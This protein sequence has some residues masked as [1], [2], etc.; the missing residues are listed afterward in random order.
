[1]L[2]KTL[3]AGII[4]ADLPWKDKGFIK[5]WWAGINRLRTRAGIGG[6]PADC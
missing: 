3:K 1:M 2:S 4:A 5:K 6:R